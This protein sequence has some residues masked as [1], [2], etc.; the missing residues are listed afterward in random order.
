MLGRQPKLRTTMKKLFFIAAALFAAVSFS[1][2]SDEDES[3][4]N[5]PTV[6]R[7]VKTITMDHDVINIEYDDQHRIIKFGNNDLVY[8]GNTVLISQSKRIQLNNAGYVI[9]EE[10]YDGSS[11]TYR[12]D[13]TYEYDAVGQLIASNE[14]SSVELGY[15]YQWENGN[16]YTSW[17]TDSDDYGYVYKETYTTLKTPPC[18]LDFSNPNN[19]T[20]AYGLPLGK[21]CSNLIEIDETSSKNSDYMEGYRYAYE[22]DQ[23]GYISKIIETWYA[24]GNEDEVTTYEISY[25]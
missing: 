2:C 25:Y 9:A 10:S 7:Y 24:N 16:R 20:E 22:F 14:N 4:G 21:Q 5:V 18:N 15:R 19:W 11:Q 17:S 13:A 1:A 3:S 8:D 23:D 12:T 6:M